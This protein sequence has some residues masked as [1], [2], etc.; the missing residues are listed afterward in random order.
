MFVSLAFI[1]LHGIDYVNWPRLQPLTDIIYYDGPGY[2]S[3]HH[4]KGI[5]GYFPQLEGQKAGERKATWLSEKKGA[6]P[7]DVEAKKR[8][9]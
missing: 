9:D 2:R 1:F 4:G 5:A 6:M 7:V 3:A 8:V